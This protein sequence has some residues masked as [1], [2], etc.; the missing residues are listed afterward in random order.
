MITLPARKIT[1]LYFAPYGCDALEALIEKARGVRKVEK[2][3]RRERVN[4]LL[5]MLSGD[6]IW[7]AGGH[8]DR[9]LCVRCG[10]AREKHRAMDGQCPPTEGFGYAKPDPKWRDDLSLQEN[11]RI[12]WAHWYMDEP[13]FFTP[14]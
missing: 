11:G 14:R 10:C 6:R 8:A 4:A 7:R 1:W 13:R 12:A 5:D 3:R 9:H 2:A